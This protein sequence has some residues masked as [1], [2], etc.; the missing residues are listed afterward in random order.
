M[1]AGHFLAMIELRPA[2]LADFGIYRSPA[3]QERHLEA[4]KPGGEI[5]TKSMRDSV[6]FQL[7][8]TSRTHRDEF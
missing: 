4:A 5:L 7:P 6:E 3:G 2:R 1:T 8:L